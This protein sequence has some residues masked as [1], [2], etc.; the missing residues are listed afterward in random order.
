MLLV[1]RKDQKN[2]WFKSADDNYLELHKFVQFTLDSCTDP[3]GYTIVGNSFEIGLMKYVELTG[4]HKR[5]FEES[6]KNILTGSVPQNV[7]Q[8]AI[9]IEGCAG[10][11]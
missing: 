2:I 1:I 9:I 8:H 7:S 5:S 4:M 11:Q 6:R 3:G 10:G